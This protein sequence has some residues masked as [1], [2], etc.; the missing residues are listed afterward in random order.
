MADLRIT[1]AILSMRLA[2]YSACVA[3]SY[4]RIMRHVMSRPLKDKSAGRLFSAVS[5]I[6]HEWEWHIGFGLDVHR[7]TEATPLKHSSIV[8][9]HLNTLQG[10]GSVH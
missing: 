7:P 4:D 8:S 9:W 6:Y 10:F 2:V 5:R 1:V 3:G